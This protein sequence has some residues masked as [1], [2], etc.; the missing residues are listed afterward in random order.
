MPSG[1]I[2][3]TFLPERIFEPLGLLRSGTINREMPTD[4]NVATGYA[5]L[6]DG[7]LLL[8]ISQ[9]WKMVNPKVLLAV[10]GALSAACSHGSKL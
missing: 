6:D 4:G 9:R 7:S 1:R 2:S 5:V 8:S 10:Y 3:G